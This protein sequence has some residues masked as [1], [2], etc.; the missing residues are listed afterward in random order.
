MQEICND[1]RIFLPSRFAF[2]SVRYVCFY[3]PVQLLI[4]SRRVTVV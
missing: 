2:E 1:R 4:G 3:Y